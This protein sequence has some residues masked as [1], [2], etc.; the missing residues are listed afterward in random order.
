MSEGRCF[1]SV[2]I[3]GC[4][5]TR[6]K[7]GA[8]SRL[9]II[10]ILFELLWLL[11]RFNWLLFLSIEVARCWLLVERDPVFIESSYIHVG[12]TI[13][14]EMRIRLGKES[15][16]RDL[17]RRRWLEGHLNSIWH[18]VL[19]WRVVE[20]LLTDGGYDGIILLN[21][22][23]DLRGLE[24]FPVGAGR[25]AFWF[26]YCFIC[27]HSR[28]LWALLCNSRRKPFLCLFII[29]H[30]YPLNFNGNHNVDW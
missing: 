22:L 2:D 19:A 26:H 6:G 16:R 20:L 12:V 18:F 24:P 14:L 9:V 5:G 27:G 28:K 8:I 4:H 1:D 13:E 11:H 10:F 30:F 23:L 3:G 21:G 7:L 15:L 25:R 17:S 29:S